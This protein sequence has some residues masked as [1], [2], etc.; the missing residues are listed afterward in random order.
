MLRLPCKVLQFPRPNFQKDNLPGYKKGPSSS[1]A[2]VSSAG[3]RWKIPSFAHFFRT[4]PKPLKFQFICQGG[5]N[6][7]TSPRYQ[8]EF[9]RAINKLCQISG[10]GVEE[11][12]ADVFNGI[13]NIDSKISKA[14][15]DGADLIIFLLNKQDIPFYA[16]LKD[17]ADRSHGVHSLCLVEQ[18]KLLRNNRFSEYMDNVAMKVN[19]KMGGVT[20]S[21]P[22]VEGYLK[23][24]RIMVLGADVVHAGPTAFPGT[25]SI[26]AI[27]GSVDFSVGKCLGSMRL[28]PVDK[29]DREVRVSLHDEK[30]QTNPL[31]LDDHSCGRNGSRT[32]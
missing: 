32:T 30:I 26:A 24:N 20:Q 22:T 21:I 29:D 27:V 4:N 1:N 18:E 28:Q 23:S 13:G 31:R 19:W 16:K 7:N 6:S 17:V 3:S 14:K 5:L 25:P 12:R 11:L 10:T 8:Q 2:Q 9:Q 15:L